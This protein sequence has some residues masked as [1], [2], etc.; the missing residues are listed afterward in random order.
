MP[1]LPEPPPVADLVALGPEVRTVP[2]EALLWRVYFQGGAH[3]TTWDAFREWGPSGA[4]FDPHEPPA[5]S[6]PDRAVLY[7]AMDGLT[8]FAEVFQ[9]HRRV[10]RSRGAPALVAF[11]TT[12]PL[13]L[14]DLCGNWTT[15]AGASSAIC[16]GP[17][18]RARRWARA[19]W[20]AWPDL[21]GL[22][23]ASSMNGHALSEALWGRARDALPARPAFHRRLDDPV[24]HSTVLDAC[25]RL[26]YLVI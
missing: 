24:L 21:D 8:C 18:A 25:A 6:Q 13:R 12:R 11:R 5:R 3:P 26:R 22:L 10:H 7:T 19:F 2:A 1:K 14:L 23:Y 16:S 15:R 9:D 17:R 4:R 20:E